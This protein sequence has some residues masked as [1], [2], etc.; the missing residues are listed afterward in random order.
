MK[1][2][3]AKKLI[4]EKPKTRIKMISSEY[5]IYSEEIAKAY[6][7]YSKL[8]TIDSQEKITKS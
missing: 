8:N 3:E 5:H 2:N 1:A 4:P 6:N 7:T